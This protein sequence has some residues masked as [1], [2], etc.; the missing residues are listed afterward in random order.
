M[1]LRQKLTHELKAVALTTLFFALCFGVYILLKRLILAEYQVEFRGLS[2]ALLGAFIM[3]KVVLVLDHVP[4]GSWVRHRPAVFE[5]V[6]RTVLYAAGAL[7]ALLLETAF[8]KRHEHGGFGQSVI[9]VFQN[10]DV[11]HVW[12]N[13]I[14]AACAVLVFNALSVVHHHLGGRRLF[15]LFFSPRPG[16]MGMSRQNE[17]QSA[18]A[19]ETDHH[20]TKKS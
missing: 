1:S 4:L 12:A 13:V 7:I 17:A 5:V 9:V 2:L 10:R 6:L 16:E 3:A 15:Q 18:R 14:C 19:M 20:Q 8:E 11:N